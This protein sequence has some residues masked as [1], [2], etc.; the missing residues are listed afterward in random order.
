MG[1]YDGQTHLGTVNFSGGPAI[2]DTALLSPG[3]HSITAYYFGETNSAPS[4]SAP[5]T[6]VVN[7]YATSTALSAMPTTIQ[8][9]TQV[10]LT[11]VITSSSGTPTG[12]VVFSDGAAAIGA[13]PLDGSGTA[14]FNCQAL[15]PG[16]AYPNRRLS[17]E[18]QLR[19]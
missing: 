16:H 15:D 7:A 12:G 4:T 10:S 2:F 13:Q 5:V 17:A 8:A 19:G 6:V 3:S 9:G 14:V 1:F 11:A 18:R